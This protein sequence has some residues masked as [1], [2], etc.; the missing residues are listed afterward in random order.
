MTKGPKV[1]FERAARKAT[2]KKGFRRPKKPTK[3][4]AKLADEKRVT[5]MHVLVAQAL[6]QRDEPPPADLAAEMKAGE[7]LLVQAKML[8]KL[9]EGYR[10]PELADHPGTEDELVEA[11]WALFDAP[12]APMSDEEAAA[13]V[14]SICK[15]ALEVGAA[16]EGV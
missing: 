3:A 2:A 16:K 4:K 7:K 10:P 1:G 15:A 5:A 6:A 14:D 11:W 13:I 12:P 8:D 9:R